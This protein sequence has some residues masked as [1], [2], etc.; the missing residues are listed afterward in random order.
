MK[1]IVVLTYLIMVAVNAMANIL[2]IN[3]QGTG[4]VSDAYPNL[5]A[6]A[7]ITFAIWGLIYV[8]LASYAVY[9]TELFQKNKGYLKKNFLDKI[10]IYFSISSIANAI[11]IYSW[12]YQII[13]LSMLLML[14]ILF[15]LVS[16]T[17]LIINADLSNTDKIFIKLPFSIYFGWIT[18]ATIANAT[19]LLVS[20]GWDGFGLSQ[21]IWTVIM[22]FAGAAIGLATMLRNK[23]IAYGMVI[24][25]AY[26]GILFKHIA[27][28]G[29][30][31][32]YPQVIAAAGTCI[33]L[34][35]FGA[36]QLIAKREKSAI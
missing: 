17:K 22:I 32:Q 33:V 11:W 2:P 24:I 15:C 29:F 20:I 4:Q 9:Q 13:V 27:A 34:L 7:G 28:G 5:F 25:W 3:G 21:T 8:L 1:T 12:H 23:D 19:V 14:M 35:V 18:V 16:I 26:T 36:I 10:G 30:N 6:P 31:G